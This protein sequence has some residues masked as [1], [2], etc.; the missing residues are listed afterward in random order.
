MG[1]YLNMNSSSNDE[2]PNTVNAQFK[3][4]MGQDISCLLI[5]TFVILVNERG[6]FDHPM[7][8][9]EDS[10]A[11]NTFFKVLYEVCSAY[12]T[13]GLSLGGGSRQNL[14]EGASFSGSW[15]GVSKWCLICVMIL[16]KL[17][18]LPDSIDP[19]VALSMHN[20][21]GVKVGPAAAVAA[22]SQ[23]VQAQ[24]RHSSSLTGSQAISS[25]QDA[26]EGGT[27]GSTSHPASIRLRN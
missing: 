22:A 12:G 24:V 14:E 19:S 8:E 3:R 15:F 2:S 25:P 23:A 17:R 4:Y 21:R 16:G 18:G 5:L 7:P 11:H 6:R 1:N 13:V 27:A 10:Y 9:M 26:G 20:R